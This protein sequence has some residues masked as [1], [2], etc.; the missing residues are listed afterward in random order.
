MTANRMIAPRKNTSE[1][2]SINQQYTLPETN[3]SHLKHWGW[4]MSS[5]LGRPIFRS[6]VSFR[7]RR[8][9]VSR[10]DPIE[11]ASSC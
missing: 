3:S 11:S 5:V 4:K 9:K 7:E 6:Y 1:G 10:F 8:V 2:S